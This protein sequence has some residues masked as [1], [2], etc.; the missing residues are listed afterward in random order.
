MVKLY[1]EIKRDDGNY[2]ICFWKKTLDA[3]PIANVRR[4]YRDYEHVWSHAYES[5]LH[6]RAYSPGIGTVAELSLRL[7]RM[8]IA[9]DTRVRWRI[10]RGFIKAADSIPKAPTHAG[11]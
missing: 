6:A 9:R 2:Q 3:H 7:E 8:Y 5:K 10:A 11:P 1:F 4:R